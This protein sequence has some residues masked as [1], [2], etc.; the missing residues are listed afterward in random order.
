MAGRLKDKVAVV[1]GAAS[2]IGEA[3]T[4]LF[5]EEGAHVVAADLGAALQAS[6]WGD[7]SCVVAQ[8]CDVTDE[9]QIAA[10]MD[11]AAHHF[12]GIDILVNCAGAHTPTSSLYEISAPEWDATFALLLRGPLLAIKYA[13]RQMRPRGGGSIINVASVAALRPVLSQRPA[14]AVAKAGL[15]KLTGMAAVELAADGIRVN[16]VI[17][18]GI[19][20]PIV[21][22]I[23]GVA[24]ADVPAHRAEIDAIFADGQPLKIAGQPEHLGEAI[25]FLASDAS[26]FITGA[27]LLVDGALSLKPGVQNE[28][29]RLFAER[30]ARHRSPA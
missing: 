24:R 27:E 15:I 18:G 10:A 30:V 21:S 5:L 29:A 8:P 17:P 28:K 19:V 14:Y 3:T 7:A 11:V 16:T 20:T 26:A 1:T 6:S 2:G 25:L 22:E 4:L 13:A 9:N 12:G 23:L